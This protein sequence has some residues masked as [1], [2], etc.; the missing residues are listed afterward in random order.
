MTTVQKSPPADTG[1][2]MKFVKA[3]GETKP[4]FEGREEDEELKQQMPP[5]QGVVGAEE[6]VMRAG[7]VPLHPAVI[8]LPF[9]IFGRV[10]TELTGYPGFT[11][12]E[13][14]LNDL[15]EL[16]MQCGVEMNPLL[17]ASIGTTA[18][19][20]GKSLGYFAWVKAGKP[21][22]AGAEAIGKEML[23]KEEEERV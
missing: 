6:R 18:M 4:P 22:I 1:A 10:G 2:G 8:R 20:G 12:T 13:M 15:A 21:K 16:W 9:S 23:E 14:E 5:Q 19:V 7:K 11:F 3:A 17:Q